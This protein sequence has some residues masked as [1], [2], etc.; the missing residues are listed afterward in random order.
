MKVKIDKSFEKDTDKVKD[1][2]LLVKIAKCIEQVASATSLGQI[3]NLKKL[4]GFDSYYRIK[5]G[6]YRVGIFI[7]SNEARFERFLHRKDIHRY[8][9]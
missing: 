7:K 5:I 2:K 8:Y 1:R 6:D 4:S 3:N 9:P